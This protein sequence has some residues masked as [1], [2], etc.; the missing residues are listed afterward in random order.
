[1]LS[2]NIIKLNPPQG[3]LHLGYRCCMTICN[4]NLWQ[5]VKNTLMFY[6][7]NEIY[8]WKHLEISYEHVR[9]TFLDNS[10]VQ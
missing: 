2:C 9:I 8:N 10:A 7:S 5:L 1:M 6:L 4:P 3:N